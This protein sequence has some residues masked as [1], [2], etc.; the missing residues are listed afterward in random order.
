MDMS[1]FFEAV[2]Y[3]TSVLAAAFGIVW[4]VNRITCREIEDELECECECGDECECGEECEC[5]EAASE[6]AAPTAE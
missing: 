5:C 2:G 4:L 1:K 6:E 3:I